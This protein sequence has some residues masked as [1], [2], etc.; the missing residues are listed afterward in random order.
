LAGSREIAVE[1]SVGM[2]PFQA[3][4]AAAESFAKTFGM[5]PDRQNIA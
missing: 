1:G 4:T 3:V 5:E 2:E